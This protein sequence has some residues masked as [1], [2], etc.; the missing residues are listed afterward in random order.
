M[1][2]TNQE[3]FEMQVI[4]GR[5]LVQISRLL[6]NA[7]QTQSATLK[8]LAE[9]LPGMDDE[10]RRTLKDLSSSRETLMEQWEA[11]DQRFREVVE[12]F[13]TIK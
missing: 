4:T 6:S 13:A 10:H 11:D 9:K 8:V 2:P 12:M 7:M 5:R 3:L 1:P